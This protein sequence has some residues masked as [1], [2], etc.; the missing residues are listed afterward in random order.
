MDFSNMR[1]RDFM[2]IVGGSVAGLMLPSCIDAK[3]TAKILKNENKPDFYIRFYK[4]FRAVDPR[5]WKLKVGGQCENPL[6]FDLSEIKR[7]PKETQVSRLKCVECWSAKAKWGGFRPKTLFDIVKPKGDAKFLYFYSA[8]DYYE[9]IS[10]EELLK[11][12]VLFVYEMNDAPLPDIH[13]APLRLIIPFKYGYKNVKTI[14][15]LDFVDKGRPGYWSNYGYSVDGTI[16][17]GIDHPLD[18]G[19]SRELKREGEVDYY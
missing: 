18:L 16:R 19:E 10:I 7:L 4:P 17:P 2:K 3:E 15:K 11:P 12:R 13:G 8:D 5:K 14:V 6:S 1:R 9:Y